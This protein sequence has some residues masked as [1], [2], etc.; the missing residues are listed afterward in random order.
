[1]T[2]R[3]SEILV[4]G[5][6]VIGLSIAYHLGKGGANVA[7]LDASTNNGVASTAA[8]GML[9]PLA[10]ARQ[11]GPFLD[12][13]L[14]SLRYYPSFLAEMV[15][16]TGKPLEVAGHG[17]LRV[18]HTEAEEAAQET[19][20]AWQRASGLPLTR[21]NQCE[22]RGLE[23][24]LGL[25]AR[26]AVFSPEERYVNP[27]TLRSALIAACRRVGAE[28]HLMSRVEGFVTDKSRVTAVQTKTEEISGRQI[29]LCGGAW[30]GVISRW[31]GLSLPVTP[32]RGQALT[33]GSQSPLPLRH[34]IYAH[35]GYLVPRA[36][37]IKEL[38]F[39]EIYVGATEESVGFDAENTAGGC[40]SLLN[41]AIALAPS[42]AAM[43]IST[44]SVGLRPVSAD[45]LPL[46]GRVP[47]WDNVHVAT[48]HGRNG[49][50]LAPITG[51]LMASSILTDAPLPEAFDPARFGGKL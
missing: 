27:R 51:S 43:P 2:E 17:M 24:A 50:L 9:A 20:F 35:S 41:M 39:E 10:E 30:S 49:I 40:A 5:G 44:H 3:H 4:I 37:R 46:L 14:S 22:L 12:M 25:E 19:A 33:L 28:V 42:L 45:G 6:G 29:V 34:T 16:E 23:P 26:T 32:L 8:A 13:G 38:L 36:R 7:V 11:P 47:G 31:L 48:G 18:T 15:E 1:M 21:L